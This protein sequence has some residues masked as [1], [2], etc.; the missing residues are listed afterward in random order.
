MILIFAGVTALI[1]VV[2]LFIVLRP[3]SVEKAADEDEGVA[4]GHGQRRVAPRSAG[5]ARARLRAGHQPAAQQ[6]NVAAAVAADESEDDEEKE[7]KKMGAKKAAKLEAKAEKK[8]QREAEEREREEKKKKRQ[9]EDEERK[10]AE[11]KEQ[12]EEKRKEEEE[13]KAKE[14]QERKEHEEYLKIKAAFTIEEEGC[15]QEEI[16]E[17]NLLE[18]FIQYV[19]D[20]KV[21]ALDEL[22][23]KFRMKTQA[24]IDRIQELQKE[25]RLSGVIDDRGKFIYI[26]RQ[27]LEGI[28]KFVK[29]RGRVS[30]AE[31]AA[32]SNRIIDLTP[33]IKDDA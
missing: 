19:K 11:E 8:A 7:V 30:L 6:R 32:N 26:S 14:E 10:K 27:E 25:E 13:R 24:A 23:S 2:L 5:A 16:D 17:E 28:A 4:I 29:Q 1:L 21:V 20:M 9:Q 15:D 31:L 12:Q 18:N 3:R 22:A 33:N